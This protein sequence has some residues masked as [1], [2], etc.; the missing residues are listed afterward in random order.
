MVNRIVRRLRS[1]EGFSLIELLMALTIL[2]VGILAILMA[3]SAGTVSIRQASRGSTASALADAQMELYRGVPY[4]SIALDTSS[5]SSAPGTAAGDY[6]CDSALGASCPNSTANE[7]TVTCTTPLPKYCK[8]SQSATGADGGTY[9]VDTYIQPLT[10]GS[11]RSVRQVTV[12]VRDSNKKT[13]VYVRQTST[14]D[15]ATG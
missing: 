11:G 5:V 2:N 13:R 6:K 12:V 7:V 1:A 15:Q 3:F 9:I 4:A 8:A 10:V 14:F